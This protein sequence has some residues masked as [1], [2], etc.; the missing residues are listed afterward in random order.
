MKD[1]EA[2]VRQTLARNCLDILAT[3]PRDSQIGVF[4]QMR[5]VVAQ[6]GC[7]W[8][9]RLAMADQLGTIA[10][11][12]DLKVGLSAASSPLIFYPLLQHLQAHKVFHPVLVPN[13]C[14][15]RDADLLIRISTECPAEESLKAGVELCALLRLWM[16]RW[17]QQ[18]FSFVGT[19]LQ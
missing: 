4:Q 14:C 7:S 17:C 3:L 8:R 16:R 1:E 10:L 2:S 5:G 11:L 9:I 15:S 18:P 19:Q 13:C 6:A 12:F